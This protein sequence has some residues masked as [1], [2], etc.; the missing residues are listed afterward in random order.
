MIKATKVNGVYSA[1]PIKDPT[2]QH[3]PQLSYDEVIQRRLA[4]MD[5]TAV[6]LCRDNHMPLRVLNLH[7]PGALMHAVMGEDEGTL[8]S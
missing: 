7:S 6:V 4:V 2:A 1:D 8:V 3:Y 5:T